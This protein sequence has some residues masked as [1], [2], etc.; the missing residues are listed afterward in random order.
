MA[1]IDVKNALLMLYKKEGTLLK[2]WQLNIKAENVN[3]VDII[4]ARE[5]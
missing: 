5:H 1:D 4:N 2:K 3:Y